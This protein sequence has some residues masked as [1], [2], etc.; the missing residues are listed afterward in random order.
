MWLRYLQLKYK[1]YARDDKYT[2]CYG[3]FLRIQ[4]EV[5]GKNLPDVVYS[6]DDVAS[7]NQGIIEGL[8]NYPARSVKLPKAGFGVIMKCGG[9]DS[10][11]GTCISDTQV[12]HITE[13]GGCKIEPIEVLKMRWQMEFYEILSI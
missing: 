8:K 7:R 9:V 10:H 11:I 12:I 5:Y 3:L 1:S 4:K 2:D 6:N 13:K